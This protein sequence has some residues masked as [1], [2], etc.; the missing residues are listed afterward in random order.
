MRKPKLTN[1]LGSVVLLGAGMQFIRPKQTNP[2]ID[3]AL[4]F[5]ASAK[6]SPKLAAIIRRACKDCHSNQTVWPWYNQIAPGSWLIAR[7]VNQARR[8]LNFSEWGRLTP[9]KADN[10]IDEICQEARSHSMPPF[11]Y[12][13]LHASA[14][15]TKDEIETLCSFPIGQ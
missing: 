5:E 14:K 3:P 15:L 4:T 13:L 1:V 9:E 7:D 11:Q 12:T 6:P 10:R 8:H 2:S